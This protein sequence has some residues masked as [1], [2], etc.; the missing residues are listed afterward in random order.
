MTR[1]RGLA[2][3]PPTER[4]RGCLRAL[5]SAEAATDIRVQAP[6]WK[7]VFNFLAEFQGAQLLGPN[8]T[9]SFVGNS[10]QVAVLFI[11]ASNESLSSA[12]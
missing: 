1:A 8:S 12:V 7:E 10:S 11:P 5:A 3:P 6:V 9:F 4:P 2:P